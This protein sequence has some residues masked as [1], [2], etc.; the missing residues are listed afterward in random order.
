MVG[1]GESLRCTREGVKGVNS[2]GVRVR[3][4]GLYSYVVDMT[5][6]CDAG[7]LSAWNIHMFIHMYECV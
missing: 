2:K 3:I 4:E 1:E 7:G 6:A 5:T